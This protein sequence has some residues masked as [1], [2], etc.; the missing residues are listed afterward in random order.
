LDEAAVANGQLKISDWFYTYNDKDEPEED[1][2]SPPHVKWIFTYRAMPGG[3]KNGF[4]LGGRFALAEIPMLQ[5]LLGLN[6]DAVRSA[7]SPFSVS[8]EFIQAVMGKG[9]V[10]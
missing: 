10:S 6:E 3:G 4:Q 7:L 9:A 1:W 5:P 8:E 2:V